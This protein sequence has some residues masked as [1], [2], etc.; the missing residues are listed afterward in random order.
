M[1]ASRCHAA[2]TVRSDSLLVSE[3]AALLAATC[4]KVSVNASRSAWTHMSVA[5]AKIGSVPT[6][7]TITEA[8]SLAWR[9]RDEGLGGGWGHRSRITRLLS[10]MQV[11]HGKGEFVNTQ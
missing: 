9:S 1:R 3:R 6:N 10:L 5:A 2:G 7:S 11:H 4:A 8:D